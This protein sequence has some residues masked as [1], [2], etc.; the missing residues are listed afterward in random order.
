[1]TQSE[2][3]A[4]Q[5]QE[6]EAIIAQINEAITVQTSSPPKSLEYKV[7]Y[8]AD[9]SIIT[10]TTEELP[11][12]YIVV[13]KEQWAEA[14]PDA[15]VVDGQLVYTH[16]KRHVFKLEPTTG[17]KYRSA[18]W[19]MNILLGEQDDIEAKNWGIRAYDIR[20]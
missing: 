14:R 7:Y 17:G 12:E 11:G 16:I 19:D 10:Y 6:L 1:M 15:R 4:E 5:I 8:N 13:T 20:R 2:L 18:T 9:G 3:S